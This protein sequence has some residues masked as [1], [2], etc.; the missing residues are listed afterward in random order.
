[1]WFISVSY[2]VCSAGINRRRKFL[3]VSKLLNFDLFGTFFE[4]YVHLKACYTEQTH[5]GLTGWKQN[6]DFLIPLV[7]RMSAYN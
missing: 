5:V 6:S 3:V 2:F 4:E 7:A 1:M